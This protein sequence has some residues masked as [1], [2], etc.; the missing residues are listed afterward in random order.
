MKVINR[1]G[2]AGGEAR[3][4]R[5][6]PDRARRRGARSGRGNAFRGRMPFA[7]A[8]GGPSLVSPWDSGRGSVGIAFRAE[9]WASKGIGFSRNVVE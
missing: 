1:G 9:G 4:P 8:G 6:P 7:L 2:G 3:Q 5:L